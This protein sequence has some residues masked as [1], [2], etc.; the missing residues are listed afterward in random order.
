MSYQAD[1][2]IFG[3]GVIGLAV[4]FQVAKESR[5]VYMLERVV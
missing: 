5:Q 3:A 4:A 2:F 1:I